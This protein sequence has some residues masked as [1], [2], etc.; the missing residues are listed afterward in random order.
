MKYKSLI[1]V[2]YTKD[3]RKFLRYIRTIDLLKAEIKHKNFKFE[4][5]SILSFTAC[6]NWLYANNITFYAS[7]ITL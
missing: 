3:V 4:F 2:C 7:V 5:D 6:V 1:V